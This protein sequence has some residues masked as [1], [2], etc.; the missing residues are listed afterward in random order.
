ME[1]R[2]HA[3]EVYWSKY[4]KRDPCFLSESSSAFDEEHDQYAR[5]FCTNLKGTRLLEIGCGDGAGAIGLVR[6]YSCRKVFAIDISYVR[7]QIARENVSRSGLSGK[8]RL[9]Q[10]DANQLAFS[11]RY[12]DVVFCNSV[13][14]FLDRSRFFPKWYVC[15]SQGAVCFYSGKL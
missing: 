3:P 2:I 12:F 13:V 11:D 14:L 7:L 9:L 1:K 4:I 15:S 8:I 6:K 5:G 10:M